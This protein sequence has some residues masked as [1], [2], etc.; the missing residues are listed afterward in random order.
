MGNIEMKSR[1][2]QQDSSEDVGHLG[3]T[4][5]VRTI[6]WLSVAH[7]LAETARQGHSKVTGCGSSPK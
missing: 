5:T 2:T 1:T 6:Q 7:L 4:D 3:T